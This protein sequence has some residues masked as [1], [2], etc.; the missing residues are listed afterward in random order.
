MY[1]CICAV[2]VQMMHKNFDKC[3]Y[4]SRMRGERVVDLVRSLFFF[5][6]NILF[7]V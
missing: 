5:L 3:A 2:S 6:A 4:R 7:Y 1:A